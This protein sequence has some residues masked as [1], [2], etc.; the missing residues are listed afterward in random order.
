MEIEICE[1][2]REKS[3]ISY[4]DMAERSSVSDATVK[5]TIGS[6]VEKGVM[7]RIGAKR[8]RE[9][10]GSRKFLDPL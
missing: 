10:G 2:I 6:L 1:L 4:V 5:R 7:I 9:G 8:G 3:R